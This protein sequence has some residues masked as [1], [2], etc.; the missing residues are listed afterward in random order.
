MVIINSSIENYKFDFDILAVSKKISREVF[1]QENIKYDISF[2]LSIVSNYK[3]RKINREFRNIDKITDV[4]S[5]P[6]IDFKIVSNFAE[7]IVK[8]KKL[9]NKV[10]SYKDYFDISIVDINTNT[11]F[12]GDVLICYNKILSQAKKYNHSPKREYSFLLLH[13]LLHL[14][15]YDHLHDDEERKMFK[16]QDEILKKLNIER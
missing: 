4:L 2:N 9:T 16:K 6:N 3:I 13:S 8:N 11:I 14:L 12:L 5:F 10:I 1:K 15:G 7:F